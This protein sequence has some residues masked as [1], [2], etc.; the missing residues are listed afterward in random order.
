MSGEVL[1]YAVCQEV[2]G[3][4]HEGRLRLSS[5]NITFR[6]TKTGKVSLQNK[7]RIW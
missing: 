3:A 7:S 6:D 2:R 5:Q 4:R 1:D